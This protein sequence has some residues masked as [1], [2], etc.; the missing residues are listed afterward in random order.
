VRS[1]TINSLDETNRLGSVLAD[2]LIRKSGDTHS[3]S[4]IVVGLCGTLGAG[5]TNLAQ[6]FI[7]DL[8]IDRQKI[9]SPTFSLVQSYHVR[10]GAGVSWQIHHVDAYRIADDDEFLQLG[11]EEMMEQSNTLTL[12]E[13]AGKVRNCLPVETLWIELTWHD[14]EKRDVSF[15]WQSNDWQDRVASV[16]SQFAESGP[17]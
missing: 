2:C 1:I 9:T 13:W 16:L 3:A 11:I 17:S 15:S 12:I 7:A 10:P 8:G 5:K 6:A 4:G 14:G